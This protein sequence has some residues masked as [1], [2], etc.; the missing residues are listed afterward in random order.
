MNMQHPSD[1]RQFMAFWKADLH[2]NQTVREEADITEVRTYDLSEFYLWVKSRKG[3]ILAVLLKICNGRL[4]EGREF[5]LSQ[6]PIQQRVGRCYEIRSGVSHSR[7]VDDPLED[8]NGKMMTRIQSSC[9]WCMYQTL[10]SDAAK[11]FKKERMMRFVSSLSGLR[12][13]L[14]ARC[15]MVDQKNVRVVRWRVW[16]GDVLWNALG[17]DEAVPVAKWG[18]A[19]RVWRSVSIQEILPGPVLDGQGSRDGMIPD[20]PG[21]MGRRQWKEKEGFEST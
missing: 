15:G 16:W 9:T 19:K 8:Q 14:Y 20:Y 10:L 7:S 3:A 1:K 5:Q 11:D 6:K 21:D 17:A 18:R 12:R 2:L 4:G 13:T